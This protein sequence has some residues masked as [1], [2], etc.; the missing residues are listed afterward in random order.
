MPQA[1]LTQTFIQALQP[2]QKR[3]IFRDLIILGL[4]LF[5]EPSG[6]KT[7]YADYRRPNGKRTYHKI[8][9]AEILTVM[10]ARDVAKEFLASVTLGNDPIKVEEVKKERLTL[11]QLLLGPYATWVLDSRRSGQA[12][13]DMVARAFKDFMDLP[14]EE[15]T[16]LRIEQWRL[17]QRKNKNTKGSS[18][19]RYTTALKAVFNWA[20]KRDLLDANPLAKLE[21]LSER[22]S[23][24]KVRFLTDEERERFMAALDARENR[25]R[26]GRDNHNIWLE[27]R[28]SSLLPDMKDRPFVDYFKP[29][30]LVCLNT[31][32]RRN[33]VF[34]LL[35]GDIDFDR[36]VV[37]LR[38]ADAKTREQHIPMTDTIYSTLSLWKQQCTDTAPESLVFPSPKT[39]KK[40]DNCGSAW[41]NL[42]KEA[43]IQKFRWHDM[44]HDF[45]SQLVMSGVDLNTVRELMGHADLKMTLRYA[46]LAPE[47]K[48]Q[49][50]R[51]L[52]KK[53]QVEGTPANADLALQ[54]SQK[55]TG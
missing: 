21:T 22:D 51:V 48:L 13:I 49:A 14:V 40:M 35:W 39:H 16:L 18:L 33:A 50:I 53:S 26:Q 20:V 37:T 54:H 12:T 11:K 29:L 7:W 36:R 47:N 55:A 31:G 4:V 2:S 30:I 38:D 6:K 27:E 52:D 43:N 9:P 19:N 34:S 44:R 28:K 17:E 10:Q 23:E 25:M 41:E 15:I 42:L 3:Q 1:K 32:A 5:V 46:H 45:A 8:G 24:K